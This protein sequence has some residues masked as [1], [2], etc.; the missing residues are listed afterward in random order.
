MKYAQTAVLEM[1]GQQQQ[2]LLLQQVPGSGHQQQSE[3]ELQRRQQR[4][5]QQSEELASHEE[6]ARIE[7]L[8]TWRSAIARL[9]TAEEEGRQWLKLADTKRRVRQRIR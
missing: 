8:D 9:R 2:Q 6:D 3:E 7:I 4:Q 1:I 5:I